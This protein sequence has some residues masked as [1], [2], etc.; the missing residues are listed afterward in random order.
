VGQTKLNRNAEL[1]SRALFKTCMSI[2]KGC[3]D[4]QPC[5]C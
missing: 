5:I 2:V 4:L 1:S 3:D